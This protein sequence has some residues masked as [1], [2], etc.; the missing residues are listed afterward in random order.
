MMLFIIFL[1]FLEGFFPHLVGFWNV[2]LNFPLA[3]GS[4]HDQSSMRVVCAR[5]ARGRLVMDCI[6]MYL[7]FLC[8]LCVC[9]TT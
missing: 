1:I 2:Q 6:E 3:R 9:V 8:Y 7:R 4:T 5:V